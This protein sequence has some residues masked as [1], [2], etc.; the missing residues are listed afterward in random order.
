MRDAE[1]MC[2]SCLTLS[3]NVLTLV[4]V[5]HVNTGGQ[6]RTWTSGVN[7][8]LC[9]WRQRLKRH[10]RNN[11]RQLTLAWNSI[12]GIN[13]PWFPHPV[14]CFPVFVC[15]MLAN[16]IKSDLAFFAQKGF[17]FSGF[18]RWRQSGKEMSYFAV[19]LI[20]SKYPWCNIRWEVIQCRLGTVNT[21]SE[22][23]GNVFTT[24]SHSS[25]QGLLTGLTHHSLMSEWHLLGACV[26]EH[27]HPA[28]QWENMSNHLSIHPSIHPLQEAGCK[29]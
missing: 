12:D 8:R 18:Y 26:T 29:I 7:Q 21:I 17:A 27:C 11:S 5:K 13:R 9:C 16:N 19:A 3:Y 4:K 14:S 15:G 2:A 10:I 20:V 24:C 25:S 23:G 1:L 22:V 28:W 6:S